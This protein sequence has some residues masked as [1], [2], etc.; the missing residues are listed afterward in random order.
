[1]GRVID[2][3]QTVRHGVRGVEIEPFTSIEQGGWNST[4]LK[5]YSHAT[6]HM[7]APRHF[8]PE[9][10]TM[11]E[12]DLDLCVGPAWVIDLGMLAPRELIEVGHL[13]A[14]VGRIGA[15][16]RLLLRSGWSKRLGTAAY[17]DELPRISLGLARWLA[18]KGIALVG[19]EPP[20][21]AAV[22]DLEEVTQVHRALLEAGIVI[23][24]GLQNLEALTAERVTFIALPL[25]IAG[26]DGVPVRAVALEGALEA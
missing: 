1:M 21:V 4:T 24:E 25:K 6:T 8:V 3:S 19:V 16:D 17:R 26:G 9:G 11:D 22:D 12:L 2:L 18:A 14:W 20:S 5:L 10:R 23:V 13:G 7:D 15:G